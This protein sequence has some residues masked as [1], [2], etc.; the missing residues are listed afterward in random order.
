M[1]RKYFKIQT[2]DI[3]LV[4]FII[5][6]Y[7]GLATVSTVDSKTAVIAVLIMPDFALE[8]ASL[9]EDL[10]GR[11]MLEDVSYESVRVPSC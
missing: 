7:E 9:L 3:S 10:K 8:M 1:I 2:S 6:G 5:E 4:Q 11:F